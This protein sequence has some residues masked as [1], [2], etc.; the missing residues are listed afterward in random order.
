LPLDV[1]L[2]D[3]GPCL[4]AYSVYCLAVCVANPFLNLIGYGATLVIK[5][6]TVWAMETAVKSSEARGRL[7]PR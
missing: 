1:V 6:L 5:G 3:A 4:V 7:L 2:S